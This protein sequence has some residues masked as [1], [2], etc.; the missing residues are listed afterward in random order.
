MSKFIRLKKGFNI[1]LAGKAEK[2]IA[3]V[4]QPGTFAYKP[5]SFQ[6]ILR[7][8][9]MVAEGDNVKAGTPIL[10]DK[11]NEEVKHVAPV[12]GEV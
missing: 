5:T 11:K 10:F 2:K 1:N 12:S 7:P 3:E 8:K 9:L 4:E 6:G